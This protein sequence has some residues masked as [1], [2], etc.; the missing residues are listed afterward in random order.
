M[1]GEA[2]PATLPEAVVDLCDEIMMEVA[3]LVS[4][5]QM[6]SQEP[7]RLGRVIRE[8][9]LHACARHASKHRIETLGH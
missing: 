9:D 2:D 5:L 3:R 1:E 7:L 6:E 8:P 4:S